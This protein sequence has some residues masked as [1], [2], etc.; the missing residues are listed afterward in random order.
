MRACVPS[1]AE[2]M[3]PGRLERFFPN[4]QRNIAITPVDG[5]ISRGDRIRLVADGVTIRPVE[6]RGAIYR[7]VVPRNVRSILLDAPSFIQANVFPLRM[8]ETR[9]LG[10]SVAEI[11]IRSKTGEVVIPADD[12]RLTQGWYDAER[13][14]TEIWRWTGGAA[15]IPWTNISGPALLTI[16]CSI[17]AKCLVCDELAWADLGTFH[18]DGLHWDG[19][20][21]PQIFSWI[22]TKLEPT[23]LNDAARMQWCLGLYSSGSTWAFNA[24]RS[25]GNILFPGEP[26]AGVYAESVDQLPA[27]WMESDRLI[28][29]SHHP[30]EAATAG[31]LKRADR[32]W[33]TIRDPRDSVASASTYIFPD[34]DTALAAVTRSALH[35]E[36]FI[37]DP[38]SVLLRY[39][40]G[41]IDDPATLDRFAAARSR[42]LLPRDRDSLFQQTRRTAIE[43][44]IQ[45]F[46]RNATVE[47][48]FP[49][50]SRSR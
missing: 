34:F 13:Q 24:I 47:D 17:A 6:I 45:N 3:K 39:E 29:K 37:L 10:V 16:R 22:A 1:L 43:S 21:G 46:D 7:F 25:V 23:V 41:F 15:Q 44:M 30:D 36:R 11:T 4:G 49:G 8:S 19:P 14:G 40:D 33:I 2:R 32:I 35:C 9:S 5:P 18:A 28:I 31:F 50:P 42:T 38:R 12:P 20:M 48:G 27:G 26:H